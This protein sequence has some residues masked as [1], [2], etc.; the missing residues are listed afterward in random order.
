[1]A[2]NLPVGTA[3][4]SFQNPQQYAMHLRLTP[5]VRNALLKAQQTGDSTSLRLTGTGPDNAITVG[6]QSFAFHPPTAQERLDVFSQ[7]KRGCTQLGHIHQKAV[8]KRATLQGLGKHPILAQGSQAQNGQH[9]GPPYAAHKPSTGSADKGR[10][11]LP[12]VQPVRKQQP[13]GVGPQ[14]VPRPAVQQKQAMVPPQNPRPSHP[15]AAAGLSKPTQAS[16]AMPAPKQPQ[17]RPPPPASG[18]HPSSQHQ[19]AAQTQPPAHPSSQHTPSGISNQSAQT[20]LAPKPPKGKAI[21]AGKAPANAN[22]VSAQ[23]PG[24]LENVYAAARKGQ[25]EAMLVAMLLCKPCKDKVLEE[26]LKDVEK[27]VTGFQRLQGDSFKRAC[28]SYAAMKSGSAWVL[29]DSFHDEAQKVLHSLF[30]PA[31]ANGAAGQPAQPSAAAKKS[32]AEP[33][34]AWQRKKSAEPQQRYPTPE[35]QELEGEV[36]EPQPAHAADKVKK[37]KRLT[38]AADMGKTPQGM[39]ADRPPGAGVKRKLQAAGPTD[40]ESG[41][42]SAAAKRQRKAQKGPSGLRPPT[43]TGTPPPSAADLSPQHQPAHANGHSEQRNSQGQRWQNEDEARG[44]RAGSIGAE[45]R[46]PNLRGPITDMDQWEECCEEYRSKRALYFRL[47]KEMQDANIKLKGL[48]QAIHEAGSDTEK[49]RYQ[50]QF[51]LLFKRRLPRSQKWDKAFYVLQ[52][53]LEALHKHMQVFYDQRTTPM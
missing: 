7:S 39:E 45:G 35:P 15:A 25:K 17:V 11:Q 50:Q 9:P 28:R 14:A 1:M 53:E 36:A 32:N 8:V 13:G 6:S 34:A 33:E 31:E 46:Q 10:T 20:S 27:K 2:K 44:N 37:K 5:E 43:H 30:A 47:H 23:Q 52:D 51:D 21:K 41:E 38:K 42:D 3:R 16:R 26:V 12:L 4:Y 24:V 49:V 18:S 40:S 19:A 48:Q 29:K 22:Y